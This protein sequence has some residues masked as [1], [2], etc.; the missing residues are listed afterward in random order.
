MKQ[1]KFG[2]DFLHPEFKRSST[3]TAGAGLRPCRGYS[4]RPRFRE[5]SSTDSNVPRYDRFALGGS[6]G[7][8]ATL[9]NVCRPTAE[10]P[11]GGV[12]H[13]PGRQRPSEACPSNGVTPCRTETLTTNGKLHVINL[14][15][16]DVHRARDTVI[17][18]GAEVT[19]HVT[20]EGI[21]VPM[22]G[23]VVHARDGWGFALE[24]VN[25]SNDTRERLEEF[26]ALQTTPA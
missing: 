6:R 18:P 2:A 4:R 15:R 14:S 25:L 1:Y 23:R 9:G 24:F 21:E 16:V 19:V 26:L 5:P 8:V 22:S 20:L 13:A 3:P 7:A 17:L 11:P 10:T 12:S